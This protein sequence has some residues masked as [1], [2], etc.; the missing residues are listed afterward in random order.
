MKSSSQILAVAIQV[1][2]Q[3]IVSLPRKTSAS[4]RSFFARSSLRVLSR[5]RPRDITI[6]NLCV[7]WNGMIVGFVR[8]GKE[9]TRETVCSAESG[10]ER[11]GA[12]RR[13]SKS[14]DLV[15]SFYDSWSERQEGNHLVLS[16]L[17]YF[18]LC[19][20]RLTHDDT[21]V[22]NGGNGIRDILLR[23]DLRVSFL[24]TVATAAVAHLFPAL[25]IGFSVLSLL[26]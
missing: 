9:E 3:G 22:R 6:F 17:L 18:T 26:V 10:M 5:T 13:V 11:R 7:A 14:L 24:F 23:V 21:A 12:T 19:R 2:C 1:N 15:S 25:T 4:G 20:H 8:T 16:S